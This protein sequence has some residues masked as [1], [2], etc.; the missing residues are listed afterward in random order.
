[1][2]RISTGSSS[3]D[4]LLQGGIESHAVTEFYGDYGTG[5]TQ[6]ALTLCVTAQNPTDNEESTNKKVLFIDTENTFRAARVYQ[7]AE[8]RGILDPK[9]I[10]QNVL[11]YR[12]SDSNSLELIVADLSSSF[13]AINLMVVDSI[14]SLYRAEYAA[15]G[16]ITERQ[17]S[18]NRTLHCLRSIAENTGCAIVVT[19]QIQTTADPITHEY[20]KPT[21]GNILGHGSTYRI[22]LKKKGRRER[23]A[24]IVDSP[25]HPESEVPFSINE[26]GIVDAIGEERR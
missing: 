13:A 3:L 22:H 15:Q 12:V 16:A 17:Q 18:L 8:T 14:I 26:M 20:L 24:R 11:V 21:G 19:N 25:C 2:P 23:F 6:L 1:M 5:K 10:L 4:N 7:I 9:E